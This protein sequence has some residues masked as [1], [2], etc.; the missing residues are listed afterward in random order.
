MGRKPGIKSFK[1]M[2]D[3][4]AAREKQAQIEKIQKTKRAEIINEIESDI[5]VIKRSDNG[6]LSM[7]LEYTGKSK[8]IASV[9]TGNR[10]SVKQL[11]DFITDAFHE[12][13][14]CLN[15]LKRIRRT[16]KNLL[17]KNDVLEEKKRKQKEHELHVKQI[18][19]TELKTLNKFCQKQR[20]NRE[21]KEIINARKIESL[22][23]FTR[24]E[25]LDSIL[26][27]GILPREML[28]TRAIPF[29]YNDTMR[30]D[31]MKSCTCVSIEFPNTWVMNNKMDM[32]PN[33]DWVLILLN[34]ELLYEQRNYYAEHNAA[35]YSVQKNLGAKCKPS[36]FETL[37]ADNIKIEKVSGEIK[38]FKRNN[39]QAFFPTSDQAEVLVEGAINPKFI[40]GVVFKTDYSMGKY[41][42]ILREK[43][44]DCISNSDLFLHNRYDF[45]W[46]ER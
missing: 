33:S 44:I 12:D 42:H 19:E 40:D 39:L 2:R 4:L 7:K 30:A 1:E 20:E 21:L 18:I 10:C 38:D 11:I 9:V 35:T 26:Q 41:E 17:E 34:I 27:M 36:D 15:D 13:S 6:L 31:Y 25:N 32:V 37:F 43:G 14:L 29:I 22:I 16:F 28:E 3:A 23:H 5:A 45:N 46:E 24:I 8:A